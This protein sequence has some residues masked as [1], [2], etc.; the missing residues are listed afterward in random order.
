[1][2]TEQVAIIGAELLLP[3][4]NSIATF[5][6]NIVGGRNCIEATPLE[7][8][9]II[10]ARKINDPNGGAAQATPV[11]PFD[12]FD[13]NF[14]D[15]TAEEAQAID[16]Q[17]RVLLTLA[18]RLLEH[19]GVCTD[20]IGTFVCTEF[21]CYWPE[22]RPVVSDIVAENGSECAAKR[23][24]QKLDLRGP[25]ISIEA[26]WSSALLALHTARIAIL[27]GQCQMALVG[28]AS[29]QLPLQDGHRP[30]SGAIIIGLKS[31]SAALR[32]GSEILG[33]IR[34][35]AV[36]DD[37]RPCTNIAALWP[38]Q[39]R[40]AIIKAYETAGVAP[41]T[42]GYMELCGTSPATDSAGTD[43][44]IA[45]FRTKTARQEF[46]AL[47][48][49]VNKVGHIGVATSLASVLKAVLCLKHRVKPPC[50][51]DGP[52][53]FHDVLLRSPFYLPAVA[54]PWAASA[55]HPRRASI[56]G[57][58]KSVHA[59][60]VI[61]EGVAYGTRSRVDTGPLLISA[62][63]VTALGVVERR[64]RHAIA[65]D[66]AMRGD[67]RYTSQLCRRHYAE[68][69]ALVFPG[70]RLQSADIPRLI[71]RTHDWSDA[72]VA[73]LF[74]EQGRHYRRMGSEHYARGGH[75]RATFDDCADRFVT[76]GCQD[77]R[78]LF[79][80]PPSVIDEADRQ[81][82]L[83]TLE[84]SLGALFAAV[85]MP[86]VAA[87]GHAVGEYV[88][89]TLAG[90]FRLRDAIGIVAARA[91]VTGRHG[92]T[93]SSRSRG[94]DLDDFRSALDSIKLGAPSF[95]LITGSGDDEP[96][97]FTR[98][99]HWIKH[100]RSPVRFEACLSRLESMVCYDVGIN[101]GS[102]ASISNTDMPSISAPHV[103]DHHFQSLTQE[104][105]AQL[106]DTV[107]AQAWANDMLIDW[108]PLYDVVRGNIVS[109]P[110]HPLRSNRSWSGDPA[111]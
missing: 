106:V 82:Y 48:S 12:L 107:L 50:A 96:Q 27:T 81:I 24:A 87:L 23:I 64:A 72:R 100:L 109:V 41:D 15:Y 45:A 8:K 105:E 34:S 68:R 56:A 39:P 84:Y 25:A 92:G 14:F 79:E 67:L 58:G 16:P 38:E 1:M 110:P 90:V 102:G 57:S 83:F 42:V 103:V 73:L 4:A 62:K 3:G 44:V 19:I 29:I 111:G 54:V 89:A 21:P 104:Q 6:H 17:Q 80:D 31:L 55:R 47:G 7:E 94:V 61:E 51:G 59:H 30:N 86:I 32:D 36:H 33:L 95:R 71:R 52:I 5:W 108:E 53:T 26:G 22:S 43:A 99:D 97:C 70:E 2:T 46:C 63:T 13:Y 40:D 101:A 91:R 9:K 28:A 49:V 85:G 78:Q 75:F 65:G 37:A 74:H 66:P 18:H 77:P 76:A 93:A 69:G 98:P 60:V 11:H 35:S 20:N 88:A 10:A